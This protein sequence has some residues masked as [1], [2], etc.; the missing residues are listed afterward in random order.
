M[1]PLKK[2]TILSLVSVSSSER[3]KSSGRREVLNATLELFSLILVD[4]TSAA[5]KSVVKRFRAS[6]WRF[7]SAKFLPASQ[8]KF[9]AFEFSLRVVLSTIS[10]P[11]LSTIILPLGSSGSGLNP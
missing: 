10:F 1:L 11:F 7:L 3:S 4:V 2:P 5:S 6:V 8:K 9:C